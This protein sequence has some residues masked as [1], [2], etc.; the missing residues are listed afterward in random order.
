MKIGVGELYSELMQRYGDQKWWP[1]DSPFEVCVGAILT[2]NTSWKNV[3]KAIAELKESI[4]LD[5]ESVV[6]LGTERL[7]KLIKVSG[8]YRQKARRLIDFASFLLESSSGDVLSLTNGPVEEVRW[9][10]MQLE[11][12]GDETADAIMLYAGGLPVFVADA[13]SRRVL[14]RLGLVNARSSYSEVRSF[15]EE[16]GR[17]DPAF[18]N[19]LHALLVQFGKDKCRSSPLCEECFLVNRCLYGVKALKV[20][21][22]I[23]KKQDK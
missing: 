15:V 10:L 14:S 20:K 5:P 18:F 12:I 1:A 9:K 21:Q 7:E 11:G 3:E 16:E 4:E 2:Q 19:R 17:H 6:G 8:F 13:Y 23:A 22:R